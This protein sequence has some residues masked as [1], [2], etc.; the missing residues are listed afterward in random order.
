MRLRPL[1]LF[2]SNSCTTMTTLHDDIIYLKLKIPISANA[3]KFSFYT[4]DELPV[5][6]KG[7]EMDI[8]LMSHINP[9]GSYREI[10]R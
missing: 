5:P 7:N 9:F 6:V 1:L 3:N 10:L 2:Y 4:I 8:S